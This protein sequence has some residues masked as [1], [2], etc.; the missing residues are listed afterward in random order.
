MD[1]SNK[2]W[3]KELQKRFLVDVKI[4]GSD[5]QPMPRLWLDGDLRKQLPEWANSALKN[6]THVRILFPVEDI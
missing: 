4:N 3:Y 6:V 2:T 5:W 1:L